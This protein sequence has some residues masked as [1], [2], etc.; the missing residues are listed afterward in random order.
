[1]QYFEGG[2]DSDDGGEYS[3]SRGGKKANKSK[4]ATSSGDDVQDQ[5]Q[6]TPPA[7]TVSA[8]GYPRRAAQSVI[9]TQRPIESSEGSS[10]ESAPQKSKVERKTAAT[11]TGAVP[12]SKRTIAATST[13]SSFVQAHHPF[14]TRCGQRGEVSKRKSKKKSDDEDDDEPLG[15]L[16]LC[17]CCSAGYHRA[18]LRKTYTDSLIGTGFRCEAC[19]KTKGA[20]CLECHEWVGRTPPPTPAAAKPADVTAMDTN[21]PTDAAATVPVS[22]AEGG[23]AAADGVAADTMSSTDGT[24]AEDNEKPAVVTDDSPSTIA[25]DPAEPTVEPPTI[26]FR[27][28]RCTYT[29]HDKCLKRLSTMEPGV[30][31]TE[32]I[33][34]YRKDWKCHQCLEWDMELDLI[35]AF[36]DVPIQLPSA[37]TPISTDTQDAD[38][39]MQLADTPNPSTPS[40]SESTTKDGNTFPQAPNT[41]RE[42]LIK[43]KNM[44]YRKLTWVPAY[45]VSQVVS[46]AKIKSFWKRTPAPAEISDVV[47]QEWLQVEKVLDVIFDT[48]YDGSEDDMDALDHIQSVFVKWKSL[49]Y[50]QCKFQATLCY[51]FC[52][53]RVNM[54][55]S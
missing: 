12:K 11:A 43:W 46:P 21:L 39:E 19:I 50:D 38:V 6:D 37:S 51:L 14:C 29:A 33:R 54:Y 42:L 24:P 48:E 13:D 40:L 34:Q 26:L 4:K 22:V 27:C 5:D 3:G 47:P 30:S 36:R 16:L 20:E 31:Q 35:L 28:F 49:D 45:W 52:G 2:D 15:S 7:S 44:S 1:V 9:K 10:D 25:E 18:C 55:F 17:E 53:W 41:T 23:A 8:R 32:I